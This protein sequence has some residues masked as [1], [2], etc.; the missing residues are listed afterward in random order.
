MTIRIPSVR[1]RITSPLRGQPNYIILSPTYRYRC[2]NGTPYHLRPPLRGQPNYIILSPTYRYRCVN[3]TPYHLR[4]PLRGHAN[5]IILSPG[6]TYL[7]VND[8]PHHLRPPLRELA[9]HRVHCTVCVRSMQGSKIT[10]SCYEINDL[11][12]INIQRQKSTVSS[13]INNMTYCLYWKSRAL[14]FY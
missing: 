3:G 7:C 1:F 2:I 5:Y 10:L 13:F 14:L 12:I 9:R 4:P 6:Y 8:A 11:L